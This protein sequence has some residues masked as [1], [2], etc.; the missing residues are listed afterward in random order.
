LIIALLDNQTYWSVLGQRA[1][2]RKEEEKAQG[3]KIYFGTKDFKKERIFP[4]KVPGRKSSVLKSCG[5]IFFRKRVRG[6]GRGEAFFLSFRSDIDLFGMFL[7]SVDPKY[8]HHKVASACDPLLPL[9]LPM[10]NMLAHHLF[11]VQ[12]LD[13]ILNNYN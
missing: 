1:K 11:I 5:I 12:N 7:S 6:L 13:L 3:D 8:F 4:E 10:M 2:D 9:L